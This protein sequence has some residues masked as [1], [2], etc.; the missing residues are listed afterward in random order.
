MN[1]EYL[2][3]LV[4]PCLTKYD[5]TPHFLMELSKQEY[6]TLEHCCI[7]ISGI[8]WY[9]SSTTCTKEHQTEFNSIKIGKGIKQNTISNIIHL[10]ID[11]SKRKM[12]LIIIDKDE[13][14]KCPQDVTILNTM[15]S[16]QKQKQPKSKHLGS[17]KVVLMMAVKPRKIC[18][19]VK[20]NR[21]KWSRLILEMCEYCKSNIL[22]SSMVNHHSS[23]GRIHSFGYQGIFKKVNSSSVGLYAIK[24]RFND[25]RQDDVEAIAKTVEEKISIEMSFALQQIDKIVVNIGRLLLPVI[26]VAHSKQ[27]NFGDIGMIKNDNASPSMWNTNVCV[28][29]STGDFHTEKDTSYTLITVPSQEQKEQKKMETSIA[30][31]SNLMQIRQYHFLCQ[32]I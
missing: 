26:D 1:A 29:A 23:K 18:V 4:S 31:Y 7:H 10:N 24:Q 12:V 6:T 11:R 25:D 20:H 30:S 28:N 2:D 19:N 13:C 8:R 22:E 3:T 21:V 5:N 32:L 27:Y 17:G 9:K 15:L 16:M 14:L